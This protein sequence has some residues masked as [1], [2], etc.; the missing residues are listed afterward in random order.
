MDDGIDRALQKS[1][2]RMAGSVIEPP[3]PLYDES[4]IG[5]EPKDRPV[6]TAVIRVAPCR[7][8]T[9]SWRWR[10]APAGGA[11][12][13]S[14]VTA[15]PRSLVV[16]LGTWPNVEVEAMRRVAPGSMSVGADRGAV[17]PEL[18]VPLGRSAR[19]ALVHRLDTCPR[20]RMSERAAGGPNSGCLY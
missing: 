19:L 6:F 13:T 20:L 5:V 16:D 10:V 17:V 8:S 18:A 4:R 12:T 15:R 2:G 1:R 3:D 14:P 11:S 7:T 9:R